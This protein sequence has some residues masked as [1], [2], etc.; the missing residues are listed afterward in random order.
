[1]V[2]CGRD[3]IDAG[4]RKL[5]TRSFAGKSGRVAGQLAIRRTMRAGTNLIGEPTAVM[6]RRAVLPRVG[7]FSIAI[8]YVIDLEFWCRLLLAG[9]IV[10]MRDSLCAFRVS[11]DS[12]SV[13]VADS[14]SRDFSRLLDT[15]R[16]NPAFHLTGLDVFQGK[17][18]AILNR[19]LRQ[20]FYTFVL[21]RKAVP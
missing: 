6:F 15:M 19:H 7:N 3:V 4:G 9:D 5:L 14:Q 2:C 10:V 1:M 16:Q 17:A 13:Q 21:K 8:P 20:L 11:A 18:K 12:W